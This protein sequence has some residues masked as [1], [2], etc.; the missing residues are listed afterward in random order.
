M[1]ILAKPHRPEQKAFGT[2][3][4]LTNNAGFSILSTS[5]NTPFL[6]K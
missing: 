3:E 6:S 4:V 1:K 5:P 2:I